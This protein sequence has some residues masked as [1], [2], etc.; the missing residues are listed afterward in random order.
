MGGWEN[1]FPESAIFNGDGFDDIALGAPD[2]DTPI[3][4]SGEI[5]VLFGGDALA[6]SLNV[7]DLDGI[8]GTVFTGSL[9]VSTTTNSTGQIRAQNFGRSLAG[10]G[11]LNGDGYD[12]VIANDNRNRGFIFYGGEGP[13]P[14]A[15]NINALPFAEE[16]KI[17][18]IQG[19]SP[20]SGQNPIS[21][22]NTADEL[23]QGG[24]ING[25]GLSDFLVGVPQRDVNGEIDAGAV[26][27]I[28]GADQTGKLDLLGSAIAETLTGTSSNELIV[29]GAGDDTVI[30]GGGLDVLNGGQG[31]DRLEIGDGNFRRVTGGTGIDTL[32]LVVGL[33][34]DLTAISDNR[35]QEIEQIDLA[36]SGANHLTLNKQEVL[37]LSDTSN[38][39][40]VLGNAED[41]V[42]QGSGW[43]L[44]GTELID[45]VTF[46]RLEQGEAVLFVADS[47]NLTQAIGLAADFDTDGDVDGAD[48]LA[49]Q[50]GFGTQ[51]PNATPA[52]GDADNDQDVDAADLGIWQ[53]QFGSN[54]SPL[55]ASSA[56]SSET[57]AFVAEQALAPVAA[58]AQSA[59]APEDLIDA[60][61]ATEW[62]GTVAVEEESPV[63]RKPV[64]DQADNLSRGSY[65]QQ[66]QNSQIFDDA[67]D[68]FDF[69][70]LDSQTRE[71][72][73]A[74]EDDSSLDEVADALFATLA[75]EEVFAGL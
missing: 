61:L 24:D 36:V 45:T 52:D 26:F 9:S 31:D 7:V 42:D 43:Q 5:Y 65:F 15:A 23:G 50:R 22:D 21:P 63:I 59:F 16:E 54:A 68:G 40:I 60:A 33:N 19:N 69:S 49:W 1:P 74:G 3:V 20:T 71:Q 64:A 34:L 75:D 6:A 27:G 46:K 38:T 37:R 11:D 12:D 66:L 25:D 53:G 72:E 14:A 2:A 29:A 48:F 55:A 4:E 32:A 58:S 47:I 73:A 44:V 35:L 28:Y 18:L 51:A 70:V 39:F 8:N 57:S 17:L 56:G 41:T 10:V 62:L 30:G 13:F 67:S